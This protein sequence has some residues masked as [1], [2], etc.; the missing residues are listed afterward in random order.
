MSRSIRVAI[1][2]F[3]AVA[4]LAVALPAL[5]P[6]D[7][8]VARGIQATRDCASD[9]NAE[10]L[11]TIAALMLTIGAAIVLRRPPPVAVI[12]FAIA[13]FATGAL[14]G[15]LLKTAFERLRPD[16]MPGSPTG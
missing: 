15:E 2:C 10:R 5:R 4:L 8:A 1:V 7:D 3:A 13:A 11:G 12:L 6:L 16:S 14:F 9:A